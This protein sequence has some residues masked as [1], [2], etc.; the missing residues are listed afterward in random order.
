MSFLICLGAVKCL[1]V[2]GAKG[3]GGVNV[4]SST[5]VSDSSIQN[6]GVFR[7]RK[8]FSPPG[9]NFPLLQNENLT[10]SESVISWAE[11][12]IWFSG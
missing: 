7:R 6:L 4:L 12:L 1:S 8:S 11:T 9:L 3:R 5:Q 10:C 2:V